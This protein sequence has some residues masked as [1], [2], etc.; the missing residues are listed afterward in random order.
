MKK[1][2]TFFITF[3]FVT[4]T[5]Y[6]QTT[7]DTTAIKNLLEKESATWR[8]CDAKGHAD[9]WKIQPYSIILVSTT[10]GH[11]YNVPPSAMLNPPAG[12]KGGTS[13]NTNYKMSIHGDDAWV[14]HNEESTTADG[15][16]T[17]SYEIR[18][19]EKIDGEWKLVGQSIHLYKK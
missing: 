2:F 6:C 11:T 9:C 10:D 8:A 16:K 17:Y 14:S 7:D 15:K 4:V 13:V 3:F 19:L 18:L 12:K 5:T 1:L